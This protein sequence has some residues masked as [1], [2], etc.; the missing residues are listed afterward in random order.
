MIAILGKYGHIISHE[1]WGGKLIFIVLCGVKCVIC[2][3]RAVA[4]GVEATI[5][6]LAEFPKCP[7][8]IVTLSN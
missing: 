3:L 8:K 6:N 1:S 7:E 5:I 2:G 4:P